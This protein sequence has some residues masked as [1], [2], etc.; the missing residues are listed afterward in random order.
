MNKPLTESR[1]RELIEGMPAFDA[2]LQKQG[3]SMGGQAPLPL[4]SAEEF[5]PAG[6]LADVVATSFS[7]NPAEVDFYRDVMR[8]QEL[9][10]LAGMK[11]GSVRSRIN[12][13]M[14]SLRM[15]ANMNMDP[16]PDAGMA[17]LFG[18]M[19]T[20]RIAQLESMTDEEIAAVE[21]LKPE[22]DK[23]FRSRLT[24][25][26]RKPRSRSGGRRRKADESG[27]A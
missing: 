22:I 1:I 19:I 16:L 26:G 24:A 21:R 18:T 20:S 2:L 9:W 7:D 12:A 27:Q 15:Q 17:E 6:S 23:A 10:A 14:A 5:P 25:A 4:P 13:A 3:H 8:L 11:S